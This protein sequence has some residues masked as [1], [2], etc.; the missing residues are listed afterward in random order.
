MKPPRLLHAG[1]VD[2]RLGLTPG[3]SRRLARRGLLP[4]LILPD[5]TVRFLWREV[6]RVIQRRP[7][8]TAEVMH[9]S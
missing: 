9:A 6:L 7:A 5:G 8:N 4:H 2:R 1:E 3:S